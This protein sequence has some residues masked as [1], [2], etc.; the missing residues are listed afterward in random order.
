M[1]I[2]FIA[3]SRY[4]CACFASRGFG[5]GKTVW[6]GSDH[7]H[8]LPPRLLGLCFT[9]ISKS[10]TQGL[11]NKVR[12]KPTHRPRHRRRRS[13]RAHFPW[14]QTWYLT[15]APA[16]S[17]CCPC[18]PSHADHIKRI[19]IIAMLLV[20]LLLP[21]YLTYNSGAF[22]T[23]ATLN[24]IECEHTNRSRFIT[25]Y[26]ES[27]LMGLCRF[28]RALIQRSFHFHPSRSCVGTRKWCPTEM[29]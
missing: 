12:I 24:K 21:A 29:G 3:R 13:S 22:I 23:L 16:T 28:V 19:I 25:Y 2:W 5:P 27:R 4:V 15:G 11:A 17:L 20:V 7:R 6:H 18:V 1:L 9:F 14:H 8:H 26:Y 10:H